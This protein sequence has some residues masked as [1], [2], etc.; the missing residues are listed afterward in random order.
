MDVKVVDAGVN[1]DFG[2]LDGLVDAKIGLGTASYLE[3]CAMTDQQCEDALAKGG[4]IIDSIVAKGS[5]VVGF[6]E[7]GIGN[8][9]SASLLM[10]VICQMPIEDCVGHGTGVNRAQ[11]KTKLRTLQAVREKHKSI[12]SSNMFDVLSTFGGFEIAQMC[13]GMLR[14]AELGVLIL[15]DGF[16]S[17]AAMLVAQ[18]I[19]KKVLDY[20]IFCHHSNE[21]GHTD[22]MKFIGVKPLINIGL[23]LGEGTGCAV[24]YPILQSACAFFNQMASFEEATVTQRPTI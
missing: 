21:Q 16:I 12:D 11:F 1:H 17:S 5:N 9:S 6:G 19:E 4:D 2:K 15:V 18:T 23:R 24:A 13:G 14:A 22:M 8:T 10:S 20:A 7:M 3:G